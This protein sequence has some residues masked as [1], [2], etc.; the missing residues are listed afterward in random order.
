MEE[1]NHYELALG[2]KTRS[3]QQWD[4]W[5]AVYSPQGE[6]GYPKRIFDKVTGE[7]DPEVAQYWK[8]N[9]DLRYIF[10]K[11]LAKRL[12]LNWKERF[13][14]IVEIWITTI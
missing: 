12:A 9:Y 14:S 13:I 10:G 3:G 1:G 6:G 4:I 8:E 5:E 2:T 7:I 11:R